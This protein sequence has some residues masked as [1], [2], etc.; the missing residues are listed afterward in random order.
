[1]PRGCRSSKHL[2]FARVSTILENLKG[3]LLS[4][5][6]WVSVKHLPRYLPEFQWRFDRR[7]DLFTIFQRLLRA[8]VLT[9]PLHEDL[10]ILALRRR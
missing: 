7:F 5:C 3:G 4:V 9:P 10:L 8:A 2:P 6:R 1:M